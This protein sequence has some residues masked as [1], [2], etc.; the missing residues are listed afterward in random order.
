M[1]FKLPDDLQP[2][3]SLAERWARADRE[4]RPLHP[5]EAMRLMH[6]G[7]VL[8][9][10]E[11]WGEDIELFDRVVCEAPRFEKAFIGT[12]Y[13]RPSPVQLKADHLGISRT[14]IYVRWREVLQYCR[15]Q[16]HARGL[17]I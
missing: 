13:C 4:K 17:K 5:L 11:Q 10:S 3:N 15:G 12:W 16:L 14:T 7:A 2:T 8:G 9:G 1:A 6:D